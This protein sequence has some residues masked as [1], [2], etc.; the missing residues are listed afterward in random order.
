MTPSAWNDFLVAARGGA[1]RRVPTALIVD[2]PWMPGFLGM[3]TLD[4]F[5]YPDAFLDGYLKIEQ[6]FP[7]VVFIPGF[8]VEY[9][10]ANEPS[11]FGV[12]IVWSADSP[13][14]MRPLEL[15][16]QDWGRLE[17]RNPETDGLMPLVLRR[18]ERLERG[19]LPEPHRIRFAAARG[20]LAVAAHVLGVTTFLE[21]TAAEPA[22]VHAALDVITDTVTAFLRAQLAR[23]R[24]PVGILLLDDLPGMLSPRA[25]DQIALPYLQRVFN[26]FDGLLRIHHNDTP[27]PQLLP[28]MH[29]LHC[30]VWNFSHEMDIGDVKRAVGPRMALMGNVAPLG[31]LVRGAPAQ[32]LGEARA[33][34]EKAADGGGLILSAGGGLSPGTPA[35]NIDALVAA[36]LG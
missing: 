14:A 1:P 34:I 6:R 30:E 11:A 23:L 28:R 33:C 13:P 31:T 7:D 5:L 10:M 20:P 26:A 24:E 21:A 36:T 22:A 25:F 17:R 4:F 12:S 16:V 8:W 18:L 27:C 32:V 19:G 15:A 29:Q 9:G 2:S 35:E 3:N